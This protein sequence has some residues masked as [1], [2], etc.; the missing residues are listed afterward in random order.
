MPNVGQTLRS[1]VKQRGVGLQVL[2]KDY[3]ISYLL[4][5]VAR[6]AGLGEK[7]ALKGGTA[8]IPAQPCSRQLHKS[9]Q[10]RI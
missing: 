4:A 8:H 3:A 6:T 1:M 5:G 10:S 2:Q 9:C 7:V